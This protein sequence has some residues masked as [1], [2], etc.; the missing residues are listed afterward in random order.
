VSERFVKLPFFTDMT[1]GERERVID[2]VLA[3]P[4]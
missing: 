2:A 4:P 3:F 1:G